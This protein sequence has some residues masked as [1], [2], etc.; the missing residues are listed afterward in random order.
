MGKGAGGAQE[1]TLHGTSGVGQ[2][3]L[4]KLAVKVGYE[5]SGGNYFQMFK[6]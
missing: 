6:R 1:V 3:R 4:H 2:Q 5:F